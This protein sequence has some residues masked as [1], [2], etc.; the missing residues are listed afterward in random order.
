M[1][2]R[3]GGGGGTPGH[4]ERRRRLS[5]PVISVGSLRVGGSGKTPIVALIARLLVEVGERPAVLSRGYG[6]R[7]ASDGVTVV[8]DGASILASVD[9]AGD[10]PLMLARALP[11]VVV[12][13]GSSR[14]LGGRLAEQQ[15][16]ATVHVLD[17]G[18]QH[19]GVGA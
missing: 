5:R 11:R 16:A 4:P 9:A 6:R 10:E 7:A 17:D 8:S 14:Y 1:Q 18:F 13:V 19:F 15:F 3:R 12:L 2:Q